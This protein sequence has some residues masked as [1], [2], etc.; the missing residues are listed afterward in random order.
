MI[1]DL[2]QSTA[3]WRLARVGSLGA[4]RIHDVVTRTRSGW[5]ASRASVLADLVC[6]RLTG[7][8][9]EVYVTPAMQR[10]SELE[11]EARAAYE[12]QR[13][14]EVELVGLVRHPAIVGSHCSPDGLVGQSGLAEIKCPATRAHL[15]ALLSGNIPERYADQC[16]WQMA[17]TGRTWCDLAS[18]DNRLP[19]ALRLH[20]QCIE[21]DEGRIAELEALVAEF[22]VE[23]DATIARLQLV[24]GGPAEV[25]AHT[26][27]QLEASL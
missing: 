27:A 2:I 20:V 25:R 7:I 4:S 19:G 12:F 9:T 24:A 26:L 14:V 17:C 11:P 22:L 3:D 5:A 10:G 16:Q 18:Y 13:D 15:T 23:V 1:M 21:R 6:E 8:P